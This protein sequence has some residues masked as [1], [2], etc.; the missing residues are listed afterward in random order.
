MER[1]GTV[2]KCLFE[3]TVYPETLDGPGQSV[4][5]RNDMGVADW[6]EV[7]GALSGEQYMAVQGIRPT[8]SSIVEPFVEKPCGEIIEWSGPA[9]DGEAAVGE[10]DIVNEQPADRPAS[11]GM[12]ARQGDDKSGLGRRGCRDASGDLLKR[13]GLPDGILGSADPDAAGR[14]G[15]DNPVLLGLP[16]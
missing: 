6:P 12:D 15:K 7:D 13:Q 1:I 14:I 4:Q 5:D 11:G 16:A 9:R 10:V 2:D 8:S 3:L